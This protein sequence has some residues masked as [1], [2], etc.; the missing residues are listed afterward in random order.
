MGAM[1]TS[2]FVISDLHLGG[3]AASN[4][5]PSFQMCS[6]AGRAKLG[7]FIDYVTDQGKTNCK[8][9][10]V[11]NGDIVDF[12]AETDKNGK[13]SSF[14]GDDG[15]A[16]DKFKQ[17]IDHTPEIWPKLR[18]LVESGAQLTLLLG[19]HDVELSLPKTRR[20]LMK[21]IGPGKI[22]FLYDN[23]AF[24]EGPVIIEHGNRYDNWNVIS[25]DVLRA[26]RSA[27]SRGET[28][29]S[30]LGPAGSQ[31]VQKIMNPI[32][33]KFPFVDL[34]K[35]EDAAA[36][37]VLGVLDPS[38]V[39]QFPEYAKL[40]ARKSMIRFDSRGI[41]LDRQNI[42]DQPISDE[43][44]KMIDHATR[45]SGYDPNNIAATSPLDL[46]E[47]LKQATSAGMKQ[48]VREAA[49]KKLLEAF[50]LMAHGTGDFT[51]TFDVNEEEAKY[52]RPAKT[53]VAKGFKIVI[54][55]H[56]HLVKRVLMGEGAVYLNTGTWADLIK[57]PDSILN[58]D[59]TEAR[60]LFSNFLQDME[61][62]NLE[63]WRCQV[64]TFARVDFEDDKPT[65]ADVY[66]FDGPD[67]I[68]K[69][70]DGVLARFQ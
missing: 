28:P 11:I 54:F 3:A 38:V 34:L 35:P 19:N 37:P 21:T 39:N 33:S 68:S 40:A 26:V 58:G 49:S 66:F 41:P 70:P 20:L 4:G 5:E 57:I 18:N 42:A 46:L 51:R 32:K 52:L 6:S 17:I 10:L 7:Q 44:Q 16:T 14:T 30:F 24:V 60:Q 63:G 50:R 31:L 56:T 22:E 64:P 59:E 48:L 2:L 43:D 9:H 13:F 67:Q 29:I 65:M 55:G 23:Q 62:G 53:L 12:L 27:L 25:H 8:V 47:R 15:T 1:K 61:S 69:V 36:L 45:L